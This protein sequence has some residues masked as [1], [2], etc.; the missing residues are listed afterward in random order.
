M[1]WGEVCGRGSLCSR[2]VWV[3]ESGKKNEA[4]V[5]APPSS[6]LL[7]TV[8]AISRSDGKIRSICP[9]LNCS[10]AA[11]LCFLFWL[12]LGFVPGP[13]PDSV[14]MSHSHAP[15][16]PLARSCGH[17]RMLA[18]SCRMITGHP[19]SP[20][21]SPLDYTVHM[22]AL[23]VVGGGALIRRRDTEPCREPK[24]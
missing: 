20:L 18:S 2:V 16:T 12:W 1:R 9:S 22:T 6:V 11:P 15:P 19:W 10:A 4:V 3:G 21:D 14:T 23:R 17:G 5:G 7:L 24:A 13:P 8:G